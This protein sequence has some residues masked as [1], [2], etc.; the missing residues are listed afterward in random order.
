MDRELAI[1]KLK[2]C[3]ED[4]DRERAHIAADDTMCRLLTD[5]GYYDVVEEYN[6]VDKYYI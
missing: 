4:T 2:E 6:K 5:L 3:Q 1:S